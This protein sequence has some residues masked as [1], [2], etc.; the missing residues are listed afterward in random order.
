MTKFCQDFGY[1]SKRIQK[2]PQRKEESKAKILNEQQAFFI[3]YDQLCLFHFWEDDPLKHIW[4]M[5]ETG[6]WNDDVSGTSFTPIGESAFVIT[7]TSHKR[8]TFVALLRGDG[9]LGRGMF[10][11]HRPKKISKTKAHGTR[12]LDPGCSGMSIQIMKK[13]IEEY[14]I[15]NS[16]K[17]DLLLMDNLKAH[18]NREIVALIERSERCV[19]FFPKYQAKYL[20]PCDNSFFH[21]MKVRWRDFVSKNIHFTKEE[22][23]TKLSKFT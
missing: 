4:V 23:K 13:W 5:D 9:E 1:T 16:Q 21:S 15:P 20:S 7:S 11:E 12:V 22:K 19:L 8:D 6:F 17:N 10:I 18:T 2:R 14:F 3:S